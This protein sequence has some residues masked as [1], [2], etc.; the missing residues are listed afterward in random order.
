MQI[1][2]EAL[3]GNDR[4][5]AP[6]GCGQCKGA[7][8]LHR[9]GSVERN[10]DCIG[11]E[12]IRVQ[13][14]LCPRCGSTISVIPAGRFPYRS[15]RAERLELWM[16]AQSG[17]RPAAAGEGARP[18]PR[19]RSGTVLFA[20]GPKKARATYS[21]P[22]RCPGPTDARVSAQ[23]HPRLLAGAAFYRQCHLDF[24]RLS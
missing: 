17:V 9:H 13:R 18:P 19:L 24:G 7:Q 12:R 1:H 20:A 5:C 11:K 3:G 14:F 22:L 8:K 15:L 21:V 23:Q 4:P 6:A 10:A 16:D 2:Q